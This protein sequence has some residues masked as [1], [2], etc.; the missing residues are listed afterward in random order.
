MTEPSLSE[1]L[2]RA[3]NRVP[4]SA[5]PIEPMIAVAAG[6]RRRRTL[7]ATGS[8]AAT[9]AILAVATATL[10]QG[11]SQDSAPPAVSPSQ[12]HGNLTDQE[13]AAAVSIAQ[14]RLQGEGATITSATATVGAGTVADS[15]VGYDCE[16]GR[17]LHIQLIGTFPH[18]VTGG[19][20]LLPGSTAAPEDNT[21]HAVLI[22][23][24]PVTGR[25]CLVGVQTG[26][27]SPAPGAV[28]LN[29]AS[30]QE[31]PVAPEQA[32]TDLT[33]LWSLS[34]ATIDGTEVAMPDTGTPTLRVFSGGGGQAI[35]GCEVATIRVSSNGIP[36]EVLDTGFMLSC[37]PFAEDPTEGGYLTA[38]QAAD[39]AEVSGESLTLSGNRG[40][41]HL[42]SVPLR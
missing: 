2:E 16:S 36:V 12:A 35:A 11:D 25:A 33:G 17:L 21:V 7:I 40:V 14:Q 6:K 8:C 37:P 31:G 42:V 28:A 18:I 10:S 30:T 38:L 41:L 23:G 34:A 39:S 3:A 4:I 27:V 32:A 1:V 26:G 29:L 20:P 22:T 13:Y 19:T 9:V 24:D 5:P 15:N